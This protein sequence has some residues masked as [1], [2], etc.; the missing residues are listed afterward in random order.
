LGYYGFQEA[1]V[2]VRAYVDF[3]DEC[4]RD[5]F[6]AFVRVHLPYFSLPIFGCAAVLSRFLRLLHSAFAM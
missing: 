1:C 3:V 2:V 5:G 6:H 4:T